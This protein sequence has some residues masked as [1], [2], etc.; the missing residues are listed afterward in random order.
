MNSIK[1]ILAKGYALS[2]KL[3]KNLDQAQVDRINL[4]YKA[5]YDSRNAEINELKRKITEIQDGIKEVLMLKN[6][7]KILREEGR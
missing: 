6:I 2:R 5:G 7:T 4:A 3:A 1:D